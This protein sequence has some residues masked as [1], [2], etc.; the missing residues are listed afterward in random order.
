MTS[1]S[2]IHFGGPLNNRGD[3]LRK[4]TLHTLVTSLNMDVYLQ[5]TE[6]MGNLLLDMMKPGITKSI[7]PQ[8]PSIPKVP[9]Q[10]CNEKTKGTAILPQWPWRPD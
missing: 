2:T 6:K 5:I 3:L 4:K 9:K 7:F 8:F 1:L 10:I